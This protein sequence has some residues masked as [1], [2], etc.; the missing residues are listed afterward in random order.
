[1]P[2]QHLS[3]GSARERQQK[4]SFRRDALLDEP[5]DAGAERGRFACP[6]AGE[7]QQ[8]AARVG[9]GAKLLVVEIQRRSCDGRSEHMFG[10]YRAV[11]A[12]V[13]ACFGPLASSRASSMNAA[14]AADSCPRRKTTEVTAGS[15]SATGTNA[16]SVRECCL[17]TDAGTRQTP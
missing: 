12:S 14:S 1:R 13:G 11:S 3:R 16:T 17:A 4:D 10:D 2:G 8:R 7:D 15:A 6:G 5:G 9:R